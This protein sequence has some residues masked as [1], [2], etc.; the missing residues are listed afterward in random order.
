MKK[1]ISFLSVV[2][3]PLLLLTS[4]CYS[5]WYPLPL[6]GINPNSLV[7]S[8]NNIYV[9]ANPGLY[10]STD[11]GLNW[12]QIAL[13]NLPI[14]TLAISGSHFFVGSYDGVYRSTNYGINWTQTA[15][16][17]QWV[18]CIAIN[19]NYILA[20]TNNNGVFLSTDNGTNWAQTDLNNRNVYAF[21]IS[22][23]NI[24]AG[25]NGGLF[26]SVN[27]GSNWTEI[28]L[29][30]EDIR[31]LAI[32]NEYIFAGTYYTGVHFS[33][34]NGVN[35]TQTSLNNKAILSLATSGNNI[36]AG[37]YGFGVYLSRNYGSNWIQRN[38]GFYPN[39]S[40]RALLIANDFIFAA[41]Y[42]IYSY[43]VW[44]RSYQEIIGNIKNISSNIPNEFHLYQ[45]YPNP[46]NP[47][48]KIKFDLP[49]SDFITLKIYDAL[50]REVETLVNETLSAG[51]YE[52]EWNASKYSSGVYFYKL[53][54]GEFMDTKRMLFIK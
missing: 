2:L 41:S 48:T 12:S 21:A 46:F 38:E 18:N 19:G 34:N 16:N 54:A 14:I 7:I 30:Y 22:G 39:T 1:L 26:L 27:Y 37:T 43:S 10:R 51:S 52:V 24:F 31:S 11:Y 25:T 47:I 6:Y 53:Q 9:G 20:G 28:A 36:F 23:N 13:A 49:K 17:N 33:T 44:R 35:W 4:V 8:G 15:L 42:T 5:Q 50:G 29:S 32:S 40:I 3:T 45:N